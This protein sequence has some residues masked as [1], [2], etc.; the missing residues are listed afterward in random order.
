MNIGASAPATIVVQPF[1]GLWEVIVR[2]G[3]R[4]LCRTLEHAIATARLLLK[5]RAGVIEVRT[6]NGL[7]DRR[8]ELVR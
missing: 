4:P 8:I 5:D 1:H 3:V 7:V 2:P 6:G